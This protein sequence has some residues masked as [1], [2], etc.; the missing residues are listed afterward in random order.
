M[1]KKLWVVLTTSGAERVENKDIESVLGLY[2]KKNIL[3]VIR[4]D[5]VVMPPAGPEEPQFRVMVVAK[6]KKP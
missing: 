1:S 3:G 2:D 6:A 4:E 5:I